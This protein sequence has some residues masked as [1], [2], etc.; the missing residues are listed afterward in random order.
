MIDKSCCILLVLPWLVKN[1][2]VNDEILPFDVENNGIDDDD[3]G[4]N[5]VDGW[6]HVEGVILMFSC[7]YN[8]FLGFFDIHCSI[9][10]E[11][12]FCWMYSLRNSG[13]SPRKVFTK[14]GVIEDGIDSELAIKKR[15]KKKKNQRLIYT[16]DFLINKQLFIIHICQF[17][18][19]FLFLFFYW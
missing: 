9:V 18:F 16:I 7:M 13:C 6:E 10:L 1:F 2:V 15:K 11:L 3:D 8:D 4:C 17:S 14:S 12:T 19:F 5:N